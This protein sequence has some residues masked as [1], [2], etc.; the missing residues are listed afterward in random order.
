MFL[1]WIKLVAE[2]SHY[3]NLPDISLLKTHQVKCLDD[4]Y[5]PF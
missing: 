5:D 2:N 4:K 1:I 3:W